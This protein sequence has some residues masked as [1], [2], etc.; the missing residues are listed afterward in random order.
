M[1]WDTRTEKGFV[2]ASNLDSEVM[3][4]SLSG[5]GMMVA[6]GSSIYVYDLRNLEKPIQ[7]KDSHMDVQIL[8]VSSI[9]YAK[10]ITSTTVLHVAVYIVNRVPAIVTNT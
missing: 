6:I 2:F 10:G 1:S 5:L 9:P 8:C 4:M 3:S 7:S